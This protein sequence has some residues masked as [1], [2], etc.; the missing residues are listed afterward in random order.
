MPRK[1]KRK[2][3]RAI[4]RF[5]PFERDRALDVRRLIEKEKID[6][7]TIV[8]VGIG[9]SFRFTNDNI[10]HYFELDGIPFDVSHSCYEL[11]RKGEKYERREATT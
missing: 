9:G 6:P 5:T 2:F 3:T 10:A 7:L 1:A 11:V 8:A 4:P